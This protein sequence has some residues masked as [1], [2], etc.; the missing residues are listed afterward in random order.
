MVLGAVLRRFSSFHAIPST[1]SS[2][3][4]CRGSDHGYLSEYDEELAEQAAEIS[5]LAV[6]PAVFILC[7]VSICIVQV[8]DDTCWL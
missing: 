8:E 3:G 2:L 7:Q 1:R 5:V 6:D 4:L